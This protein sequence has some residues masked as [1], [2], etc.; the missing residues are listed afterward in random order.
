MPCA[1]ATRDTTGGIT[2]ADITAH[3]PGP[4]KDIYL[5]I[6]TSGEQRLSARAAPRRTVTGEAT[7]MFPPRRS[8]HALWPS[9][10]ASS[11]NAA[12]EVQ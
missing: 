8:D 1:R 12:I 2:P 7:G 3:L 4:V 6:R 9:G 10:T 11:R 5:V